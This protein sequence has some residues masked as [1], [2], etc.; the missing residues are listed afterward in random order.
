MKISYAVIYWDINTKKFLVVHPTHEEF[1]SMPKGRMEDGDMGDGAKA[2]SREML[3]ETN[4]TVDY[5]EL[6][7]AGRFEY[8]RKGRNGAKIDKDLVVYLYKT[9]TPVDTKDM[10]C[11]SLVQNH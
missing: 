9:T 4:V 10:I 7:E 3:E 11:K 8:Y 5:Q 2:A 6:A 1:W